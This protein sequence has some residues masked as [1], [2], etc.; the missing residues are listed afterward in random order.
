MNDPA[1]GT[2]ELLE[3]PHRDRVHHLLVELRVGLRRFEAVL[4]R[5]VRVV[6]AD[7]LE[8]DSLGSRRI[9][10]DHFDATPGKAHRMLVFVLRRASQLQ[11]LEPYL[12]GGL[13]LARALHHRIDGKDAESPELGPR[14]V[15]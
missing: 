10:V 6:E 4:H 12:H 2:V 1:K 13:V 8:P 14:L 15:R 7:R 5:D 11:L 3:R 9:D